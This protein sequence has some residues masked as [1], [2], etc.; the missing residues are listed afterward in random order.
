MLYIFVLFVL[1]YVY[2]ESDRI[3]FIGYHSLC[4][5]LIV[6]LHSILIILLFCPL[7]LGCFVNLFPHRLCSVVHKY[8]GR[9]GLVFR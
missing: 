2:V 7:L 9:L 3:S 6:Q 5:V 8:Q 1:V 4:L